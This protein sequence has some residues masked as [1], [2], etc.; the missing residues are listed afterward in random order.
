MTTVKLPENTLVLVTTGEE[1]KLFRVDNGSLAHKDNW[2]PT[3][4]ADDGPG[5]STPTDFSDKDLNEATFSKQI[6]ER[7][8]A[9]AHKGDFAKLV[10]IADPQT[11][12]QIRPLLHMEVSDKIIAE[13]PKTFIN[14]PVSDIERLLS[15]D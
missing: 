12:G 2:E 13:Y 8:Y 1:A 6:A 3:D 10:L 11:L 4:L 9:M 15:D 5:G 7:L 14:A